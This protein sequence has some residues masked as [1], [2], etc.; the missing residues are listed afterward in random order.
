MT[1]RP[2]TSRRAP[3]RS[4]NQTTGTARGHEGQL[5]HAPRSVSDAERAAPRQ[6]ERVQRSARREEQV[7]QLGAGTASRRRE[8]VPDFDSAAIAAGVGCRVAPPLGWGENFIS[9]W[10]C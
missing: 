8:R 9:W 3:S 6:R 5:D 4:L 7:G 10:L 1:A 2:Y